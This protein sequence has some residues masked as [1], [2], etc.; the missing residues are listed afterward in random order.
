MSTKQSHG[1]VPKNITPSTPPGVVTVRYGYTDNSVVMMFNQ[2][3]NNLQLS[4]T[5]CEQTIAA[6]QKELAA[7]REKNGG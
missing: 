4:P 5:Q 7:M 2:K 1:L 3:I 6:L